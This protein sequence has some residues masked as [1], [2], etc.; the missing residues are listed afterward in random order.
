MGSRQRRNF[1]E[2]HCTAVFSEYRFLSL[3][4]RILKIDRQV[5]EKH[6]IQHRKIQLGQIDFDKR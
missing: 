3:S 6:L 5:L 4:L 1:V 2:K